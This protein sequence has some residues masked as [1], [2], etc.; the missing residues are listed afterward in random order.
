MR[1]YSEEEINN[2]T[3]EE[4]DK[5]LD[6]LD[7]MSWNK[8]IKI[9]EEQYKIAESNG[10]KRKTVNDRVKSL[11]WNIE[12]A[13]TQKVKSVSK[14]KH[15]EYIKIA[16]KNGINKG[17]YQSRIARGWSREKASTVPA[18]FWIRITKDIDK[19]LKENGIERAT[20]LSRINK[21]GMDPYEAATRP[22]TTKKELAEHLNKVL[23]ERRKEGKN[24][25]AIF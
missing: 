3:M 5:Y 11:G 22:V 19:L 8:N 23:A 13:I 2:M 4:Y 25:K 10:I 17:C 20:Y 24:K 9:T 6:S 1:Y 7:S 21:Y 12:R 18:N 14:T 15:T 16:E